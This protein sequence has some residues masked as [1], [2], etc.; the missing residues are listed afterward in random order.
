MS[1]CCC[2]CG[3]WKPPHDFHRSAAS[4][5]GRVTICRACKSAYDKDYISRLKTNAEALTRRRV[6]GRQRM[7]SWRAKKRT[8]STLHGDPQ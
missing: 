1:K 6:L 5:D 7:R 8:E 2:S 4:S 3:Q